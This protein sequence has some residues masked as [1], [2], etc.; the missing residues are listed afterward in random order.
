M[1]LIIQRADGSY[2]IEKNGHPYHVPNEGEFAEEWANITDW[3][4]KNNVTPEAEPLPPEPT[5][6]E[7]RAAREEAIIAELD[8]IDRKSARALRAIVAGTATDDDRA[9]LTELNAQAEA[10]RAQ[11]QQ[12]VE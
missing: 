4:A 7:L 1:S 9:M 6:E 11:L 3:L 5:E 12:E 8:E 10:L 2:V